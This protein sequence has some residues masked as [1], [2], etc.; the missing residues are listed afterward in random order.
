MEPLKLKFKARNLTMYR[1][2]LQ[3]DDG[4][5][6]EFWTAHMDGAPLNDLGIT[7]VEFTGRNM[8][9]AILNVLKTLKV[10][11]GVTKNG[12]AFK[13]FGLVTMEAEV[14]TVR[15][16]TTKDG[17]VVLA[18]IVTPLSIVRYVDNSLAEI[19]AI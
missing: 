16:Y 2:T 6:V 11:E 12:D 14:D 8:S 3:R 18:G 1:R 17:L 19:N 7:E 5:K 10:G 15:R 9:P 4:T 13:Q